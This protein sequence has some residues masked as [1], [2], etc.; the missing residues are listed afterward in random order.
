VHQSEAR[1]VAAAQDDIDPG[2]VTPL[3]PTAALVEAQAPD[4]ETLARRY[5]QTNQFGEWDELDES[6]RDDLRRA[7]DE[8]LAIF[9]PWLTGYHP[10]AD[11]LAALTEARA[12]LAEE[13]RRTQAALALVDDLADEIEALIQVTDYVSESPHID[14]P[15]LLSRLREMTR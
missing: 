7:A 5:N 11:L 3:S 10:S 13:Q 2:I 15:R 14:A 12:A 6:S 4:R 9:G 1:A 8:G